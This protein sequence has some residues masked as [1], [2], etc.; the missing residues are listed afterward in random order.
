[1]ANY[2]HSVSERLAAKC[3]LSDNSTQAASAS[4]ANNMS[5]QTHTTTGLS[6]GHTARPSCKEA[7]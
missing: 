3:H 2:L 7:A 4:A 1:M 6:W 5:R